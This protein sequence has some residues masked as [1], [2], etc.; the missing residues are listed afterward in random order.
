LARRRSTAPSTAS[1]VGALTKTISPRV[2]HAASA[3]VE[4]EHADRALGLVAE[5]A[6]EAA[7]PVRAVRQHDAL[8][9]PGAAAR[10]EE[11]VRVGLGER[12]LRNVVV[13]F[14]LERERRVGGDAGGARQS[15]GVGRANGVG[16]EQARA[17]EPRHLG[18]LLRAEPRVQRREQ[19]AELRGRHEGR[20][21]V[22]RGVR[23]DDDA[24]PVPH[25]ARAERVRR[26]V[27]RA[28]ELAPAEHALLERGGRGVRHGCG[29]RAEDLADEERCG[30]GA[31]LRA[32]PRIPFS[33]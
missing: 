11:D 31:C 32:R 27:A 22:E 24:V 8:R 20:Q 12:G 2:C 7:Q 13:A 29:V 15:G 6:L 14:G 1:G 30:D 3:S 16:Q 10:E 5:D 9:A 18:G 4:R 25:A 19:R 23:P 21:H 33:L 17:R 26:A 28:L